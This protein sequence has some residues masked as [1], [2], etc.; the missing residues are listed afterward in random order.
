MVNV[1][2][3]ITA[4]VLIVLFSIANFYLLVYFSSVEDK[5][6][7]WFP[8]IVVLLGLLLLEVNILL[9]PMDVSNERTDGE[10]PMDIF[11]LV[12]L[13]SSIIMV[14]AVIPFTMFYYEAQD[15]DKSGISHQVISALK[16]VIASIVIFFAVTSLLWVFIGVAEVPI[17]K[18]EA[19]LVPVGSDPT[20]KDCTK[21]DTFVEFRVTYALY[22]ISM[23][24]FLGMFLFVL[25]GGIGLAALPIDLFYGWKNRPRPISFVKYSQEK[26][27]IGERAKE[28][29]ASGQRLQDK[30]NQHG[31]RPKSRKERRE[32]NEFRA[33]VYLLEEDYAL[34]RKAYG[35]DGRGPL[36]LQIAWGWAQ[37][38]LFIFGIII[39][40]LWMIH[41]FLFLA[42]R[43][44]ITPFLNTMLIDLDEVWG[45]FGTVSYGIFA[46]YLLWAV[47]K[48][49]FKFGLQIP[50]IFQI[51]PMRVNGTMMSSFLFNVLLLLITSFAVLQF[52]TMAFS[53][54]ARFTAIN[55]I[56]NVGVLNLQGIK[57]FYRYY[58]W[59]LLGLALLSLVFLL[60]FPRRKR[61]NK[62]GTA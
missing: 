59:A 33:N 19:G 3:I 5:N 25:F 20:C 57:Y 29:M 56:F 60:V 7:A 22:M 27:K 39:S 24:T 49:N 55:T 54:Y 16:Y 11:W 10:L 52:C 45:L 8:K 42:P 44:P 34:L 51:H 18:L 21:K 23:I 37:L 31:G 6:T 32:Y 4:I 28:L 46:F 41:I 47:M 1:I 13:L 9:L 50:F 17:K 40:L 62:Y 38:V 53:L 36:L 61:K 14:I 2:L 12:L 26:L 30:M 35:A 43:I 48:G 15:P 58:Y